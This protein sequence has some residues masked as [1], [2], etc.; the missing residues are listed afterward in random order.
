M[1]PVPR[2]IIG[3]V[4]DVASGDIELGPQPY[5]WIDLGDVRRVGVVL[6]AVDASH[7]ANLAPGVREAVRAVLPTTP[8][9]RL[10]AYTAALDRLIA[11]DIVIISMLVGFAGLALLMAAIGLYAVV[12]YSAGQRR[13]EFSTRVA[14]GARGIDVIR[15]VVGDAARLLVPGLGIGLTGG[16]LVGF[17]MR[18]ALIG[19]EPMDTVTLG[20]VVGLL[21]LVTLV[22]SLGPALRASRVDLVQSLRAE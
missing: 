20:L 21:A 3:V 8:V 4:T 15:L 18:S 11:S 14:L 16:L 6:A 19:V 22:A 13:A 1:P 5:V 12:A 17:G 7:A 2:E 10:E 9:E